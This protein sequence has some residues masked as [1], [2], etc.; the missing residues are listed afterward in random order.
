MGICQSNDEFG[1]A[2]PKTVCSSSGSECSSGYECIFPTRFDTGKSCLGPDDCNT[3]TIND[4]CAL[5]YG[6][7]Y[8][9]D[10]GNYYDDTKIYI[11][12]SSLD[13]RAKQLVFEDNIRRVYPRL[14][15]GLAGRS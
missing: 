12:R 2:D 7:C 10:T 4:E 13:E 3:C 5:S 15:V 9:P 11:D 8:D 14:A 1:T 6:L